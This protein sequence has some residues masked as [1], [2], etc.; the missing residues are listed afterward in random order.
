ME[1]LSDNLLIAEM[2]VHNGADIGVGQMAIAEGT[3]PNREVGAVVATALATTWAYLAG[4]GEPC[5]RNGLFECK[6]E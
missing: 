6:T 5:L 2:L 3:R 1:E 4:V